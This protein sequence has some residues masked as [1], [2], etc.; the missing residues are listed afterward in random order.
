[1]TASIA[2]ITLL[3]DRP[4]LAATWAEL[5]WRE[6]G[7]GRALPGREQLSWWVADATQA[8]QRTFVPIAFIA[9]G[10]GDEVLGGVGLRQIDLEERQDRSPSDR[11]RDRA[12]GSARR[13]RWAGLDS[14]PGGL[15]DGSGHHPAVGSDRNRRTSCGVLSTMWLPTR[16]GPACSAGRVGHGLDQTAP[17]Y[18]AM[19]TVWRVA[20]IP[21]L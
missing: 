9:L 17:M 20:I 19:M 3:A 5:H 15:G 6:W 7:M 11:R 8:V 4:D 12:S 10:A 18:S 21:R 13:G 14:A 2:M 1:M 16:G